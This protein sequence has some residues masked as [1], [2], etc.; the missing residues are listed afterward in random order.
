VTSL[1]PVRIG[2]RELG[3]AG[4]PSS[5]ATA[6]VRS[7]KARALETVVRWN[8]LSARLAKLLD[9]P[10][11]DNGKGPGRLNDIRIV[12]VLIDRWAK[13]WAD[14]SRNL[15]LPELGKAFAF[16]RQ[17]LAL[18]KSAGIADLRGLA[19]ALKAASAIERHNAVVAQDGTE[20]KSARSAGGGRARIAFPID[21]KLANEI[22]AEIA[23]K[24]FAAEDGG[25]P[26]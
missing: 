12:N 24:L 2:P 17:R 16:D 14:D 4:L 6:A 20:R 7:T 15:G 19:Q 5:D 18:F 21:R 22:A 23:D 11:A 8:A 10:I 1:R 9:N 25:A 13:L 3:L 26:I